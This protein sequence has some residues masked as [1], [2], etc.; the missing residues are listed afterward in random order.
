ML[1]SSCPRTPF[2][3]RAIPPVRSRPSGSLSAHGGVQFHPECTPEIFDAWTIGHG[4]K[5]WQQRLPWSE[6]IT[7]AETVRRDVDTVN[8]EKTFARDSGNL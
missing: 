1:R 7:A 3:W 2:C 4:E 6:A 5:E 8:A